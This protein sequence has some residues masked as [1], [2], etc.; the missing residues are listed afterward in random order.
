MWATTLSNSVAHISFLLCDQIWS[1]PYPR[2]GGATKSVHSQN[3]TTLGKVKWK[4]KL[5]VIVT[6]FSQ[7]GAAD[8]RKDRCEGGDAMLSSKVAA[9]GLEPRTFRIQVRCPNN[10]TVAYNQT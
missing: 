2:S 5:L 8:A 6:R 9:G 3:S 1:F 7:Q 10:R 4:A